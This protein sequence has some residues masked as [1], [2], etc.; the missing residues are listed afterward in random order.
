MRAEELALT[1]LQPVP[2]IALI[3]LYAAVVVARA[4]L[5]APTPMLEIT[6]SRP[7]ASALLYLPYR[8]FASCR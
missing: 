8:R 1:V 2:V 5:I 7:I 3:N 6:G 4:F